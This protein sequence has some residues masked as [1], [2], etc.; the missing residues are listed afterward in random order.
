MK[1]L[2][3]TVFVFM[4]A[5]SGIF[6]VFGAFASAETENGTEYFDRGGSL[7]YSFTDTVNYHEKDDV[8][9]YV[10]PI[11]P[12]YISSYT[13]AITAGGNIIAW[14]N[15]DYPALIPGHTAGSTLFGRWIWT[16]QNTYID[17][18]FATLNSLMASP[19]GG[20]TISNYLSGMNSYVTGKGRTF[21]SS[22]LMS[23]GALNFSGCKTAIENDRKLLTI[24]ADGFTFVGIEGNSASKFDTLYTRV[25][26]GAHTMAVFGWR[27]VKYKNSSGVTFRT[28]RYLHVNN[29][30]DGN[31]VLLYLNSSYT[32]VDACYITHI[33]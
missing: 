31:H 30:L 11:L 20:V 9:Y 8:S 2:I 18:L 4:F 25:Y 12:K 27:E 7:L 16:G 6:G 19:S 33:T 28:D 32:T 1:K 23:S 14:Y 22:S 29:G 21:T 15:K 17:N 3:C 24:F 26:Q 13:C 10:D 5:F